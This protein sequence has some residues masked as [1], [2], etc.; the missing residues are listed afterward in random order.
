ML[1]RGSASDAAGA[2]EADAA[3]VSAEA[4]AG[5]PGGSREAMLED[6][7]GTRRKPK[8]LALE[9][10]LPCCCCFFSH[11]STFLQPQVPSRGMLRR[12]VSCTDCCM[13]FLGSI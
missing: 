7:M 13:G 1:R 6:I 10:P 8:P 5:Q 12:S 3:A 11:Q 9:V 2:T 4:A